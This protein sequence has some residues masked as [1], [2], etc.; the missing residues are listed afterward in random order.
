VAAG[1]AFVA[2]QELPAAPACTPSPTAL[3]LAGGRFRVEVDWAV[4]GDSGAGRVVPVG[5]DDSGL[6]WFFD[7]ENWEMLVKVL[8]ACAVNDHRW[9]FAAATTDVAYTLRVTD[10]GS[11]AAWRFDHPGGDPAPAVTDTA[12]FPCVD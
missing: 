7:P 9:V 8:D 6:F 12:A 2:A 5:S 11:G 1:F 10:T 4:R 3:C